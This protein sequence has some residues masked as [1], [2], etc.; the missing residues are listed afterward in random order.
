MNLIATFKLFL[1]FTISTTEVPKF[2]NLRNNK[3]H[4]FAVYIFPF[5]FLY[6]RDGRNNVELAH[7]KTQE[8]EK[9]TADTV[10]RNRSM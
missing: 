3:V 8:R 9:L 6:G 4:D 1:E 5:T 7:Y 2:R 10:T